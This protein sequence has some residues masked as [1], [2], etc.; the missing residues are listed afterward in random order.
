MKLVIDIGYW[1]WNKA[2]S[3]H[4]EPWELLDVMCEGGAVLCVDSCKSLRRNQFPYYKANRK[5]IDT[6]LKDRAISLTERIRI[7]YPNNVVEMEGLEADDVVSFNTDDE[8][9]IICND[10]DYLSLHSKATLK[11]LRFEEWGCERI[12]T[13]LPIKR[14]NS[15][16]AFQL[17]YGD[18]ADNVS[19]LLH[20]KDRTTAKFV[21]EQ[22]NPLLAAIELLPNPN[23]TR[24]HLR[25]LMIPT[26]LIWSNIDPIEV[27][28]E[29][30]PV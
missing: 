11:T 26:P 23:I 29:R 3:R 7:R 10:K 15:F 8:D 12:K 17:M 18:V 24:D 6:D 28:L 20:F 21:M 14:G 13:S 5:P 22:E 27:A 30:H 25:L 2:Y 1:A 16:L 4:P 9:I 19:R